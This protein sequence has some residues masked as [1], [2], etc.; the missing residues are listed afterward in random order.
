[1]NKT[2]ITTS[3]V[4]YA[5]KLQNQLRRKNIDSE[6]VKVDSSKTK[7]GC[8]YGVKI[9]TRDIYEAVNILKQYNIAYSIYNDI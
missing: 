4:T 5:M 9:H 1:M 7:N 3:S 8:T 2:V 6:V